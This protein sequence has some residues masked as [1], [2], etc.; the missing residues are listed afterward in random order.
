VNTRDRHTEELDRQTPTS[1]EGGLRRPSPIEML[2]QIV[3][4]TAGATAALMPALILAMPG[5]VLLGLVF[6]PLAAVGLV[7]GLV[8][9][10]VAAPFLLV[11]AVSRARVR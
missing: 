8:A 11:R 4:L 5:I 7:L 6:I 2:E 1:P 3:D 9:A 10:V